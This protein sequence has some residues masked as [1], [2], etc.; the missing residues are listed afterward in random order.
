MKI[1][2]A[3]RKKSGNSL[4]KLKYFSETKDEVDEFFRV[5]EQIVRGEAVLNPYNTA[6]NQLVNGCKS[7]SEINTKKTLFYKKA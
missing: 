6:M 3:S 4:I 1:N 5:A 7:P 2:N